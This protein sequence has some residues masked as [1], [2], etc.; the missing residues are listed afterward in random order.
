MTKT[1]RMIEADLKQVDAVIEI[2][3]A[4]L[5]K[6]SSNPI[7]DDIVKNKKRIVL[8]NKSDLA[9]KEGN[10]AW[11]KYYKERGIKALLIEATTGKGVMQIPPS[12]KVILADKLARDAGRGMTKPLRAMV[13]GIPNVGKSSLI[14]RISKSA[15][16]KVADRPGVTRGKQWI[17]LADVELLDTPG[18]LWH[19]FE[20]Q[21][22][23]LRLAFT[24]A[25][26]DDIYDKEGVAER[27]ASY[28]ATHNKEALQAR[29]KIDADTEDGHE[30]L[31]QIAKKRNFLLSKA[32]LDTERASHIL[33]DEF[34]AG[35]LGKITLEMPNDII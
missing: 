35:L 27:L 11:I 3:D 9:S 34:R 8:L 17:R 22:V 4:R 7:I 16:T 12:L 28:L 23:S 10:E 20:D 25:I 30:L 5:P 19:K 26:K 18:I 33:L 1:V 24:G 31:R 32:E 29:Y 15:K 13:L 14:N 6:S 21:E 2:L